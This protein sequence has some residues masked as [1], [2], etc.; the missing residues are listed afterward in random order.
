MS[1]QW[2][3]LAIAYAVTA[4]GMLVGLLVMRADAR[5]WW[6]WPVYSAMVMA[7]GVVLWNLV[8][9]HLVPADWTLRYPGALYYGALALYGLLGIAL[10]VL[11]GRL[12]RRKTTNGDNHQDDTMNLPGPRPPPDE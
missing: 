8:R 4:A 5:A 11:L 2:Q 6:R 3:Q 1:T 10:G 12:T 7:L 9:G